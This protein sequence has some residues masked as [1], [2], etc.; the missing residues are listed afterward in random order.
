MITWLKAALAAA[1][2]AWFLMY[3][4]DY[5]ETHFRTMKWVQQDIVNYHERFQKT[6]SGGK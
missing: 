5:L 6:L 1:A 4:I 2:T 3:S